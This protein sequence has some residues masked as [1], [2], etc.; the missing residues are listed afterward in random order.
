MAFDPQFTAGVDSDEALVAVVA[1]DVAADAL[2]AGALSIAAADAL[3]E[4]AADALAV[5]GGVIPP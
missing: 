1:A 4:G 2:G 5:G 3:A